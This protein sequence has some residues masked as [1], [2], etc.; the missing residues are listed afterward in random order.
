MKKTN[1][2]KSSIEKNY[3]SGE[4]LIEIIEISKRYG[5]NPILPNFNSEMDIEYVYN[6]I[7]LQK[8]VL[9]FCWKNPFNRKLVYTPITTTKIRMNN[10]VVSIELDKYIVL[11]L[12]DELNE[13]NDL[14]YKIKQ[15]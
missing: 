12:I 8:W 3:L 11:E 13:L 10:Y 6:F 5:F 7:K 2:R 1:Q 15:V 14:K 4:R 9:Q